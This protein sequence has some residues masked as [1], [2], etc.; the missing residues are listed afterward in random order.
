MQQVLRLCSKFFKKVDLVSLKSEVDKLDIDKSEKVL[1]DLNSL[2]SKVEKLD[3]NKL[4]PAPV[5]LIKLIE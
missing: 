3:F 1:T 5:D 4:V 2:K